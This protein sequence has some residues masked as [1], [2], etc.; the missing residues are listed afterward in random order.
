MEG[1]AH[2]PAAAHRRTHRRASLV[3][4]PVL[5]EVARGNALP[6]GAAGVR[7]PVLRLRI[8]LPAAALRL[9]H[10]FRAAGGAPADP[11][12]PVGRG[13]WRG[14]PRRAMAALRRGSWR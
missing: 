13:A 4:P 2:G 7:P 14:Q 1:F 8:D 9:A 11:R 5:Y 10:T 3:D 6:R 12:Q